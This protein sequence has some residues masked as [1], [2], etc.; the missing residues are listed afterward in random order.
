MDECSSSLQFLLFYFWCGSVV[1]RRVHG[2]WPNIFGSNQYWS[3]FDWFLD[4]CILVP[5]YIGIDKLPNSIV[6]IKIYSIVSI[7]NI[8]WL[9]SNE[10]EHSCCISMNN[11][12]IISVF[13]FFKFSL[14][15][16]QAGT[17]RCIVDK[18]HRNQC[19]ACRLKKCL[20]MG[21]NKDGE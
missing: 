4:I 21:M 10:N 17:G 13:F 15:R 20:Q 1:V 18:A 19:Q 9:W 12:C 7:W 16:C 11:F 6:S 5:K 3:I 8:F 2:C 14:F